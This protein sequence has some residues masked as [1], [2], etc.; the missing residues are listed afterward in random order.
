MANAATTPKTK[1][2]AKAK[3]G[4]T[5]TPDALVLRTADRNGRAYGG[6]QWPIVTGAYIECPDW[7]ATVECGNGFHGYIDGL[8]SRGQLSTDADALWYV[9]EVV[10]A[11]C[12]LIDGDKSKFPR[13][14]VKYV[15]SFGGALA[16]LP[17]KMV[18]G[19]FA[20]T[21]ATTGYRS[22]AATTGYSSAATTTGKH[23]IAAA[24][25]PNSIAS[26]VAGAVVLSEW[27]S[28][29]NLI[30]VAAFMVGQNGIE[31]GKA[32]RLIGGKPVEAA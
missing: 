7:K 3:V 29:W 10:R 18:E 32:Y 13:C 14:R 20:Q 9:V 11:E 6:F 25:G 2:D 1:H 30:A 27:D 4:E 22:A 21:K 12:I 8:G 19:I 28:D 23:S 24:L 5:F 15:G 17:L 31:A 16:L 26:A